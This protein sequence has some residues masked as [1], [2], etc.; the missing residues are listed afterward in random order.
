MYIYHLDI[1]LEIIIKLF[2]F[3]RS[4]TKKEKTKILWSGISGKP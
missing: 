1:I 4:P 2:I 3:Q